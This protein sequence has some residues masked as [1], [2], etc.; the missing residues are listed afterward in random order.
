MHLLETTLSER[1]RAPLPNISETERKV[2]R[3]PKTILLAEDNDDLRYVMEC[4]LS[5]MGY[6][7][8]ACADAHLASTAFHSHPAIDL[9][10]TDFEMPSK[11]GIELARELTAVCPAL[12]VMIITG[13]LLP[14]ATMQEMDDRR[15][16]YVSKPCRLSTLE[17][18][19]Q[20]I[21]TVALPAAAA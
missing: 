11:T 8:V 6:L 4:S 5:S 20:E 21:L 13:S 10:L 12:P 16:V 3:A 15:W 7:V 9:L 1:S 14:A 19:L 18:S 17:A 2:F